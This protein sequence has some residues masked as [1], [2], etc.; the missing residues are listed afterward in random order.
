MGNPPL[1]SVD[2]S[3]YWVSVFLG[4]EKD[5]FNKKKQFPRRLLAEVDFTGFYNFP[6]LITYSLQLSRF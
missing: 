1:E 2:N 5:N 4:W 3:D 6:L